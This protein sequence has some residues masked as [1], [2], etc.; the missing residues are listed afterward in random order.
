M[1]T[2]TQQRTT[3]PPGGRAVVYTHPE[4][5]YCDRLKDDLRAKK[6]PFEEIDVS[7]HPEKWADVKKLAGEKITPVMV[8]AQGEVQVGYRGFGC[9]FD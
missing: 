1:A 5:G 6:V 2:E 7:K 3:P 8:T 4:C 9:N